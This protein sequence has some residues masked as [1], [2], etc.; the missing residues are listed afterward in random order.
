LCLASINVIGSRRSWFVLHE[1]PVL[2]SVLDDSG[3]RSAQRSGIKEEPVGRRTVASACF[4][5]IFDAI[6]AVKKTNSDVTP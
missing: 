1:Y 2:A 4:D 5:V 3:W 6:N